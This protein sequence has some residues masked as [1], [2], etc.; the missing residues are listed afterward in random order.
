MA[1]QTILENQGTAASQKKKEEPYVDG[2]PFKI[3][4]PEPIGELST[5]REPS[6]EGEPSQLVET[7]HK[8]EPKEK[9]VLYRIQEKM[10]DNKEY[11]WH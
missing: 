6:Q 9:N 8:G 11:M 5:I 7:V 10:L 3:R 4:E 1:S 2:E